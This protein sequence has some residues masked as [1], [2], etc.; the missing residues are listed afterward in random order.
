MPN[1][2][3]INHGTANGVHRVY[4]YVRRK[5]IPGNPLISGSFIIYQ[6]PEGDKKC[7]LETRKSTRIGAVCQGRMTSPLEGEGIPA[8]RGSSAELRQIGLR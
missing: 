6:F 5:D 3:I 7:F 1:D 8:L 2:G 4:S